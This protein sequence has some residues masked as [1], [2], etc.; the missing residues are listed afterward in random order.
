M[1]GYVRADNSNSIDNGQVIDANALDAEF[2]AIAA[3]MHATTGHKH[4][5]TVGGG[6]GITALGPG[7]DFIAT[8]TLFRAKTHA[9]Y[10]LGS[11]AIRFK[12][13]HFNSVVRA[14]AF[15][16]TSSTG[17]AFIGPTAFATPLTGHYTWDGNSTCSMYRPATN[18]IAFATDGQE[19]LRISNTG[20]ELTGNMAVSGTL[21]VVGGGSIAGN[22]ETATRLFTPRTI[23][24]SGAVTATGVSFDGTASVTINVTA[25][26]AT[27]LSSGTV[28]SARI[29]GVYSTL[30][31]TGALDS[32]SITSGFG[33]INIGTAIFTGV[34]SGLTTLNAANISTGNLSGA[35]TLSALSGTGV[36]ALAFL[37]NL[38]ALTVGYG[39]ELTGSSARYSSTDNISS[40][41]PTGQWKCLGHA[42]ENQAT[43][44]IR[45][46]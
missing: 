16:G 8:S 46:S 45:V 37:K 41:T 4:D 32:G 35:R 18:T 5:G 33:N 10:D 22:A 26:N 1:P 9:I 15:R 34:G 20:V 42:P 38:T 31:G 24:L 14:A 40:G 11:D 28:P 23:N 44:F 43:L 6:A 29:T 30:T 17:A 3:A 25:L 36:G 39:D 7:Q 19:R 12:D 21:S 13:G 27:N 2:D